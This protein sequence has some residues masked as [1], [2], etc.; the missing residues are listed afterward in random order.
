MLKGSD[1]KRDY[2]RFKKFEKRNISRREKYRKVIYTGNANKN[3]L[4][5][6]FKKLLNLIFTKF[7]FAKLVFTDATFAKFCVALFM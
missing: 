6:S 5:K 4:F 2:W 3:I 1:N 7:I